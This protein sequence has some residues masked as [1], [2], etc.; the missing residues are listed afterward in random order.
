MFR[1]VRAQTAGGDTR[2]AEKHT[3][4]NQSIRDPPSSYIRKLNLSSSAFTLY[5]H[6]IV[7]VVNFLIVRVIKLKVSSLR[8]VK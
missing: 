1:S 2:P 7:N 3:V 6:C 8:L 4:L 5:I